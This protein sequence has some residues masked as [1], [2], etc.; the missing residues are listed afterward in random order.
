MQRFETV[1][2][3]TVTPSG[4]PK[5]FPRTQTV[6]FAPTPRRRGRLGHPSIPEND[7]ERPSLQPYPTEQSKDDVAYNHSSSINLVLL[8]DLFEAA[9]H[10]PRHHFQYTRSTPTIAPSIR[11]ANIGASEV[12]QCHG[13]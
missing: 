4:S 8:Q 1:A 6:E 3:G 13:P 9:V 5:K 11:A 7:Q 12:S 10:L 2:D